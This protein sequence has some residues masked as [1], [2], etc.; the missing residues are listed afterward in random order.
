MSNE[1]SSATDP[2]RA[3]PDTV[4]V[5]DVDQ[6]PD[7]PHTSFAIKQEPD[8]DGRWWDL[9]PFMTWH[10]TSADPIVIEDD[11]DTK[12]D[13]S[14]CQAQV[15]TNDGMLMD[16]PHGQSSRQNTVEQDPV[17]E[18]MALDPPRLESGSG[19]MLGKHDARIPKGGIAGA[20]FQ[21]RLRS[22]QQTF[23]KLTS[24]PK[25]V[26]AP[27]L[28]DPPRAITSAGE[29]STDEMDID[30]SDDEARVSWER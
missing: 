18:S 16:T 29:L 2:P 9:G 30:T 5:V 4:E 7:P 1:S 25:A 24:Q 21:D 20:G 26:E 3:D 6:L 23:F 15:A 28:S 12:I 17:D 13:G 10:N 14:T 8:T 11:G 22:V 19:T 27:P